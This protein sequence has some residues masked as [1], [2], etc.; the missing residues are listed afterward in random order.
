M[1]GLARA[2]FMSTFTLQETPRGGVQWKPK[3]SPA[4]TE[5]FG[6]TWGVGKFGSVPT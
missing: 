3:G 2:M 4:P 6:D 5:A 1:G